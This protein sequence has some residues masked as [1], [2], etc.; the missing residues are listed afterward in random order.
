M[1]FMPIA[2]QYLGKVAEHTELNAK[3]HLLEIELVQPGTIEF[4]AGQYISIDVGDGV[5]RSYS[6][7]SAPAKNYALDLCVDITPGGKGTTYLK[8]LKPGDEVKFLGPLGRFILEPEKKLLFVATGCGITPLKSMI[9]HLLEDK[10]DQREMWLYWGLRYAE[11]MFWEE[12]FR[13]INEFYPNFH[14]RLI[15]SKPPEKWP[16]ASGHVTDEIREM[17]LG[18]EWGAYLCGNPAMLEEATKILIDKGVSEKQIHFE[19][20]S[21]SGRTGGGD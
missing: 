9:F 1:T 13:E 8:S 14:Y 12:E 5:R 16:L 18:S 11:E 3:Y 19:K 15:L 17:Q 21:A 2:Q 4:L 20:F 10:K 6:I 7:A